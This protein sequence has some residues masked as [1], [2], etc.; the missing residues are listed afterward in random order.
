MDETGREF[1]IYS[2]RLTFY[3]DVQKVKLEVRH[4]KIG[5]KIKKIVDIPED[6][7][8]QELY[9]ERIRNRYMK[10]AFAIY[11][12]KEDSDGQFHYVDS[13]GM[14]SHVSLSQRLENLLMN[15]FEI[16]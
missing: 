15:F 11:E 6:I 16:K 7:K 5:R 13:S 4:K 12:R 8:I 1:N 9:W 3:R 2:A 14:I 10:G